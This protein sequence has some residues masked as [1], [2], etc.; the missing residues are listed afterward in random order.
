MKKITYLL[1]IAIFS[2]QFLK[3]Q[4]NSNA[5]GFGNNSAIAMYNVTGNV[6]VVLN[7]NN[8][9]TVNLMS[10]FATAS[11]PDVR[12]FLVNRGLLNDAMLKI[13]S[14]FLAAPKIEMG[15]S[16]ASGVATFTKPIPAGINIAQYTTVYFYCQAF[17]QFWDFGSITTPFTTSNCAV[18]SNSIA[19][20]NNF[21]M[22]PNPAINKLNFDFENASEAYQI[23]IF[24]MLGSLVLSKKDVSATN[25]EVAINDLSKGVYQIVL[26]DSNNNN[27]TNKFVKN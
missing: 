1:L 15:L 22:Y 23:N 24:S 7:T 4:C 13:P 17:N 2:S 10:N 14:Q 26:T 19:T 8:T 16:P 18:L 25:S 11:G 27:Y 9:I 5:S 21:L 3:A 20:K 6:Q 12:I